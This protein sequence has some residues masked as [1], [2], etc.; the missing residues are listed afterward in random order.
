[1]HPLPEWAFFIG[2]CPS[3]LRVKGQSVTAPEKGRTLRDGWLLP[4]RSNVFSP[5]RPRASG[6]GPFFWFSV[7][8]M[9]DFDT[10]VGRE[11]HFMTC[12]WH[13]EKKVR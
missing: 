2:E 5:V 9:P 3:S 4:A 12:N 6:P 11:I 1:M 10:L 7:T 13:F 8:Q